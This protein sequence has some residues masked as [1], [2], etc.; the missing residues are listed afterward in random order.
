[1]SKRLQV[2]LDEAEYEQIQ[3]IAARKHMSVAEWV[4]QV[5]RDAKRMEPSKAKRIKLDALRNSLDFHFPTADIDQ[6]LAEV[7]SGYS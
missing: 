7:E 3:D 6:L 4:R 5:L 1:M 2:L